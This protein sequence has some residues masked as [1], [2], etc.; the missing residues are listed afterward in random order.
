MLVID[1][2]E[3]KRAEAALRRSELKFRNIF[4][5]SYIGIFRTRLQDGLILEAN[6]RCAEILGYR[7]PTEIVRKKNTTE[8]WVNPS[9]RQHILDELYQYGRIGNSEHPF[10]HRDGSKRWGLCS[11]RL[12]AEEGCMDGVITDISD[13]KQTEAALKESEERYA[14]LAQVSPVGIFRTNLEGDCQY[15]NERCCEILGLSPDEALGRRWID[16]LHPDDRARFLAKVSRTLT[17]NQPF[18]ME[19]RFQ[20]APERI[21]WVLGQVVAA[22]AADGDIVSYIG[23]ITDI[24]DRKLAEEALQSSEAEYR[25]LVETANS[26]I[27][28]W[29]TDGNIHFVN[30]YGYQLFGFECH[31]LIGHPVLD[32]IVP[33]VET[34]GR[35]LAALIKAVQQN[36]ENYLLIEHENV[37]K[38][39]KRVWV[40]WTNRP[41]FNQQGALIEILS[42]GTDATDRKQA[43]AALAERATLAAFR[44]DVDNALATSDSLQTILQCCTEAMVDHLGAAFARIWTLNPAAEILELQASAGMYTRLDGCYSR[45]SLAQFKTGQILQ[46]HQPLITN[47]IPEAAW[48]VEKDWA[49]KEEFSRFCRLSFSSGRQ[50]GRDDRD[51]F[52]SGDSRVNLSSFRLCSR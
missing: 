41:I 40:S 26:V 14:M 34:S 15:V 48:I 30:D 22:K 43:E 29:S 46:G 4:E 36:P 37:C 10:Y 7:S 8:L 45:V 39:G 47:N 42:V 27:L 21:T 31:E 17:R 49:R 19:Y 9:D 32:T 11:V 16:M 52:A 6:Q 51:V 33:P 20:T 13:R 2:S 23:A 50:T 44:A 5:N 18:V 1:I 24:T 38:D 28:R 12:N 25:E 3:Q 35:D